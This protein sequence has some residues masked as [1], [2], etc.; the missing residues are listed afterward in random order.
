M[1]A[2]SSDEQLSEWEKKKIGSE[3]F[4]TMVKEAIAARKQQLID[5][6]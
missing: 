1:I 2:M 3:E 5:E 6:P 4:Q